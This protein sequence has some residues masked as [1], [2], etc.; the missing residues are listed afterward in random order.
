MNIFCLKSLDMIVISEIHSGDLI[1]ILVNIDDIEDELY[2]IVQENR[3]DYLIVKYYSETS[4]TYK[5][6]NVYSLD[7]DTNI[8]RVESI[9]EHHVGGDTLFIHIKDEMYVISDEVN[10]DADSAIY[11]ESDS[12]GTDLSGFIA[13]DS[14]LEGKIE[15]PPGYEAIDAL[16]NDW[17]PPS[18]G[19]AKFKEMVD[20]I[21]QRA[22][23]QMDEHNFSA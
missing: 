14:E 11:D 19:S 21:E 18:P 15:L 16:W 2:A 23:F 1:K 10:I 8:L 3:G 22:R 4:L 13:S 5:D 6:A 7:E 17:K 9:L 20:R 12:D